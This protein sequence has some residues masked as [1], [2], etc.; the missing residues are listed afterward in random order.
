M[1]AGS[2]TAA[3][4]RANRLFEAAAAGDVPVL[5]KLLDA[6]VSVNIAVNEADEADAPGAP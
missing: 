5:T 4:H 6:G 3:E 2:S 1:G